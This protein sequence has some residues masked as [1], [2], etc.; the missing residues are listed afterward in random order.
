MMGQVSAMAPLGWAATSQL[1]SEVSIACAAN[2]D[3][4]LV[5]W[6]VS[7]ASVVYLKSLLVGLAVSSVVGA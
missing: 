3:C 5:G 4:L 6:G 1:G 2:L 7:S